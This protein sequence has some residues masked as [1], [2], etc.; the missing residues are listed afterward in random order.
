MD[1]WGWLQNHGASFWQGVERLSW[2]IAV[3]LLPLG[4]IQLWLVWQE[5][6]RILNELRKQP[7]LR[8]G[9]LGEGGRLEDVVYVVTQWDPTTNRSAPIELKI[10][11]HNIGARTAHNA[12]VNLIFPKETLIV[13]T[14]SALPTAPDMSGGWRVW[15]QQPVTH[16]DVYTDI[17]TTIT[18]ARSLEPEVG[19][20]TTVSMDDKPTAKYVLKVRFLRTSSAPEIKKPEPEMPSGS[21]D[22]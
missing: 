16:P 1:V 7:D 5:Q 13:N 11:T 9:F 22:A 14:K 21:D 12:I 20:P 3:T 2:L 18:A 8:V 10:F 6:R 4:L 15:D 19:I 17:T